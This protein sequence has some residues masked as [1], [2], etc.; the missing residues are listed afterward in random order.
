MAVGYQWTKNY[1]EVQIIPKWSQN[2]STNRS[3]IGKIQ[4]KR[5]A[6]N[7]A[8]IWSLTN[9]KKCIFQSTLGDQRVDFWAVRGEGGQTL[10]DI[11]LTSSV[12]WHARHPGG[13]RRMFFDEKLVL[14][15][16]RIVWFCYFGCFWAISKNRNFLCRSW[17]AKKREKFDPWPSKGSPSNSRDPPGIH[18][19]S[20]GGG[21]ST[22]SLPQASTIYQRTGINRY[23]KTVF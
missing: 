1:L 2:G 4:E 8:E 3:Q 23:K 9:S 18:Q 7:D 16:P 10:G 12:I 17:E 6:E 5:H 21:I 22:H 15:D 19:G 20:T 14:L 11:W 13:V